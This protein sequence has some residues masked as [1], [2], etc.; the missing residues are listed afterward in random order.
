MY[1]PQMPT[2][3][4]VR[5]ADGAMNLPW[6][7]VSVPKN[8]MINDPVTLMMS[9]PHGK[10]SPNELADQA[11]DKKTNHASQRPAQG[12]PCVVEDHINS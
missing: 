12:H 7:P 1:P 4:N 5:T 8:P 11:G 2:M 6:S 3:K 10:R 9:V